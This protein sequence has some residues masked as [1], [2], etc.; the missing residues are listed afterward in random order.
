MSENDR[1]GIMEYK[2]AATLDEV[3]TLKARVKTLQDRL[4]KLENMEIS[5]RPKISASANRDLSTESGLKDLRKELDAVRSSL[6]PGLPV[7]VVS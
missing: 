3:V 5:V 1:I 7:N 2:L 4:S 6:L